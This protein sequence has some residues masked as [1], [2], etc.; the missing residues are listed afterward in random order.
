MVIVYST[1]QR[2]QKWAIITNSTFNI[3]NTPYVVIT[4][5]YRSIPIMSKYIS[6]KTIIFCNS[7]ANR[8]VIIIS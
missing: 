1:C 4:S 3:R 7:Q 8:I 5:F 2:K 6:N